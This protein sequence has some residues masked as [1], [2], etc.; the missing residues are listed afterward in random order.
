M[1]VCFPL[2]EVGVKIVQLLDH[3]TAI[4]TKLNILFSIE[5]AFNLF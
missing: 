3:V 4:D 1:Y 5:S 2:Q